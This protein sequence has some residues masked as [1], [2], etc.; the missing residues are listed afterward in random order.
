[1]K[2][3]FPKIFQELTTEQKEFWKYYKECILSIEQKYI[4]KTSLIPNLNNFYLIN[5][6]NSPRTLNAWQIF[7][8]KNSFK[9]CMIEYKSYQDFAGI[10]G[11]H[12]QFYYD[13]YLI[14]I[15]TT[16]NNFGH[17]FIRP[18]YVVDKIAELFDPIEIDFPNHKLFSDKFYV[19]SNDK[20][21]T[22]EVLTYEYLDFFSKISKLEIE[23]FNNVCLFKLEKAIDMKEVHI[24][25]R[26]GIELD[27][28][29]NK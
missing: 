19:L 23:F 10:T 26:I 18:E 13:P 24:L 29:L 28:L 1:M 2:F 21:K 14:G 4:L 25:C 3:N 8:N 12:R 27:K 9:L 5:S 15:L 22:N 17:I 7:E 11:G 6:K 16:K 20:T